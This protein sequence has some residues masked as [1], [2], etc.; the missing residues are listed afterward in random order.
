[1]LGYSHFF[2]GNYYKLTPA[3]LSAATPTFLRAISVEL[4]TVG[5]PSRLPQNCGL[6]VANE[7][8]E[9]PKP[10]PHPGGSRTTK[11][12]ESIALSYPVENQVAIDPTPY[13]CTPIRTHNRD[14]RP[15]VNEA[16]EGPKPAPHPGG[17]RT[18]PVHGIRREA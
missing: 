8:A 12:R 18:L 1:V 17:S 14:A 4:L 5:Q 2:A 11:G 15:S 6:P 16:A 9:G 3:S 10:A 7:A 13:G